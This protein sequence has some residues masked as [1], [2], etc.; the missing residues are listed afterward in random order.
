MTATT[1]PTG[2]GKYI[3][4]LS[5]LPSYQS[6]WLRSDLVAGLIASAVI[7]PQAMAYATI[8]GLPVEVGLYTALTPMLAYALLGTSRPLS[9]STTSTIAMLTA[10]VLAG[11]AAGGGR[12]ELLTAAATLAVLVGAILVLASV[13]RLG[14]I[15][16]FISAPVLTGFKAGIGVVVFVSQ[17]SKIL[18]ISVEKGSFLQTILSLLEGLG[19]LHPPTLVLGLVTLA[20]LIFLPRLAPRL[21]APLVAVV[22]GIAASGLLNLDA[23]GIKLV[24]EVPPGLPSLSLPDLSL[25]RALLPGA[26]GIALMSFTQSIASARAFQ[27]HGEPEPEA[28]QELLA[29]GLAN[30][31]GGLLQ[32]MPS[33]GG[34]SQTAVNEQSGAR[35]QLAEI[36]TAGVVIITLLFLAPLISLMPQATLGALVLV[37]AGGLIKVSEFQKILRISKRELIWALVAFAGVVLL[38]TLEGILVAI[39]VSLLVLIYQANHPPVYEV[40]RKPGTTIYRAMVDHPDDETVPGLLILR[41]EGSLHFASSPRAMEK[42]RALILERGPQVVILECSAIPDIEYTALNKLTQ[43]EEKLGEAGIALWLAGL[44][45]APL[46]TIR[47]S[48]LGS[49]LTDERLFQDIV[50]AVEAYEQRY[51][52]GVSNA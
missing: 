27:K 1:A 40:G 28:N 30:I 36:V 31:G 6:G 48:S 19:G 44:N 39:G 33:G 12:E 24:G 32:A 17:L 8:A 22:F 42:M 37:A 35:T 5:W 9:V 7:I 14:V 49:T 21:S 11:V 2:I 51:G 38:G 43:G 10:S 52:Q 3:P 13:L 4:I 41:T 47:R 29:L 45:P 25:V 18:G 26:V 20:I 46:A 23:Q 50:E 15:A 34:T 16:N